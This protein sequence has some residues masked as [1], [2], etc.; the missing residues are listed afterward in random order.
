MSWVSGNRYLSLDEMKVNAL[1]IWANFKA[2]GWTIESVSA[3]LGNMQTESTVNPDIWQGL[4]EGNLQGGYGLVQWTEALKYI[5]WAGSDYKNGDKQCERIQ[6]ELDNSE[7]YEP[8]DTYPMTFS[9]FSQSTD[10][11]NTLAMVFLYN[12]ERAADLDQPNRGTQAD[13]WYEFLKGEEPEP[14]EPPVPPKR[15]RMPL[16]FYQRLI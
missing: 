14:P 8:T 3:M 13:F 6:W 5:S 2:R 7:Q 11:P 16:Y 10:S 15:I 9:E 12:Y 1:L 4:H